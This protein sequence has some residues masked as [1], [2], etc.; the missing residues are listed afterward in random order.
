MNGLLVGWRRVC[1]YPLMHLLKRII[2]MLIFTPLLQGDPLTQADRDVLIERLQKIQQGALKHE[3]EHYATAINAFRAAMASE[4]AAFALYLKCVEKVQFEDQ[5][6]TGQDFREWKRK[7]EPQTKSPS[8]KRALQHQLR[9][10]VLTLQVA[11]SKEPATQFAPE[12]MKIMDDIFVD[13]TNLTDQRDVLHQ[14]VL[15]TLFAQ[16]YELGKLKVKEWPQSPADINNIYEKLILPQVR[17]PTKIP[18]LRA[19]WT[20]RIQ[21]ETLVFEHWSNSEKEKPSENGAHLSGRD[22]YLAETIPEY[23]WQEEQDVYRAG[24]Q[25]NAAL[26]MFQIIDKYN[27][28]PKVIDWTKQFQDLL[29]PKSAVVPTLPGE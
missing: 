3:N 26:K 18:E 29:D 15:S 20:R 11:E 23:L 1:H 19:A 28:H 7:Q 13:I 21:Q 10:L 16:V 22:K 4:D 2:L 14:P 6:K 5:N 12:A 17:K 25:R 8:F 27:T 9:W 24:D